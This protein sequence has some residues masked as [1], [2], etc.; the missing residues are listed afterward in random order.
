MIT[1]QEF[2][3]VQEIMGKRNAIRP[4][5]ETFAFTGLMKCGSCGCSQSLQRIKKKKC[6]NGNVHYYTYYHCTKKKVDVKCDEKCV[7]FR[8]L[9]VMFKEKLD[10][11]DKYLM[12]FQS[13]GQLNTC[14]K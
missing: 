7:E 8:S 10:R 5:K 2:D 6:K 12:Q 11:F 4:Q 14:M 1:V 13:R 9:E 3:R